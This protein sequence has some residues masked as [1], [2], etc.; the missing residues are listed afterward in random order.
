MELLAL[1]VSVLWLALLHPAPARADSI[2]HI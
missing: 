2:I 1:S